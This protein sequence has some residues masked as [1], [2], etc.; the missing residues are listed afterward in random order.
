LRSLKIQ[1]E[2]IPIKE[3]IISGDR[4]HDPRTPSPF[5]ENYA[6]ENTDCM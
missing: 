4:D 1:S 3:N 2:E 5:K 6:E